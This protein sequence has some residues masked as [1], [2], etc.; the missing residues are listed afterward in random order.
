MFLFRG[1]PGIS[2][3]PDSLVVRARVFKLF[4]AKIEGSEQRAVGVGDLRGEEFPI[5]AS[6][7]SA[8]A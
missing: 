4:H 8:L 2:G 5:P 1:S 6:L 3:I 7:P